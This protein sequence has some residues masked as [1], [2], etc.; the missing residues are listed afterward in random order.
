M[1]ILIDQAGR[2]YN[3]K[4]REALINIW[5]AAYSEEPE[6]EAVIRAAR[7]ELERMGRPIEVIIDWPKEDKA[8]VED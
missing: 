2:I 7:A 3:M 6:A 8:H 1:K 4:R 5:M